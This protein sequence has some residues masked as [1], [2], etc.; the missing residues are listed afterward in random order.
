MGSI[1]SSL[2]QA[3]LIFAKWP[4]PGKV[5][6]RL[7]PP[8]SMQEAASLYLCML[9]DTLAI[10]S[11][12]TGIHRMIFFDGDDDRAAFFQAL[13]PD[14]TVYQQQ[15]MNLGERLTAAVATAFGLGH[16]SVAIIGTDSPHLDPKEI[17]AAFSLL[18]TDKADVVF[19][20]SSD[21]GYYLVGLRQSKPELFRDIPW[22][23]SKV[24]GESLARAKSAGLRQALLAPCFDLDTADDLRRLAALPDAGAA[25]QTK[26]FLASLP[27]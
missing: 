22:S 8:L 10:T 15:G 27:F 25:P 26:A 20:P 14:A 2:P 7:S 18:A 1:T 3:L 21:G 19:G 4:E 11:R 13:A 9:M 6:T 24:L 17:S 5:K 12:I 16:L 23:S